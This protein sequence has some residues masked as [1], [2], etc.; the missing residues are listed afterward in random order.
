MKDL[1]VPEP[2]QYTCCEKAVKPLN[3]N[4]CL[5][6]SV[7]Q[8][9]DFSLNNMRKGPLRV[10]EAFRLCK[11]INVIVPDDP[12]VLVNLHRFHIVADYRGYTVDYCSTRGAL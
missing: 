10:A 2:L 9:I 6:C 4:L 11:V 1:H 3:R 7:S 12:L 8:S 5:R